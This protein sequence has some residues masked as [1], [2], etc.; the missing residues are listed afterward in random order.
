MD[1][2]PDHNSPRPSARPIQKDTSAAKVMAASLFVVLL[3]VVF[4]GRILSAGLDEVAVPSDAPGNDRKPGDRGKSAP[5]VMKIAYPAACL[6]QARPPEGFGLVAAEQPEGISIATP[7]GQSIASIRARGPVGFSPSGRFLATDD[8]KVWTAT[9]DKVGPLFDD[10]TAGWAWSPVA[11]CVVA[12]GRRGLIVGIP[13]GER[14]RRLV[15]Q[16][17]DTFAFSPSGD[18]LLVVMASTDP[19]RGGIWLADLKEREMRVLMPLKESA[20]RWVFYGWSRAERPILVAAGGKG[21][22]RTD[23]PLVSFLPV[24]SSSTCGDEIVVADKG[25]L[26]TFGVTS[27]PEF[28]AA[29]D[30]YHILSV[31]CAPNGRFLA[32]VRVLKGTGPDAA[33]LVLLER[34]GSFVDPLTR[35]LYRDRTP[36]W[37]PSGTGVVLVR[38][39]VGGDEAAQQVWFLPE[40]GTVRQVGLS[41]VDSNGVPVFDWSADGVPGHPVDR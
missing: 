12:A 15:T 19:K 8:G 29:D 35:G 1:R 26:A 25:R 22:P 36:T 27:T 6:K 30:R 31:T 41:V 38:R 37:G 9:G 11:D 3:I 17:V 21:G 18:R 4:G 2:R 32:A 24:G 14:I 39:P 28:L 20:E 40:G 10:S 33:R 7:I 5:E 23:R 16:E 13:K 34:D